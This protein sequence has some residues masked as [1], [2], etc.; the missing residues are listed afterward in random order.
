MKMARVIR[1]EQ[2]RDRVKQFYPYLRLCQCLGDTSEIPVPA[3]LKK[4][5]RGQSSRREY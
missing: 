5:V 3:I 2:G 4:K 1:L